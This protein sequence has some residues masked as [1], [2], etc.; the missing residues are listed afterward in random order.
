[1]CV[2]T[3]INYPFLLEVKEILLNSVDFRLWQK[4]L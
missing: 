3:P 2:F 4:P 1:M